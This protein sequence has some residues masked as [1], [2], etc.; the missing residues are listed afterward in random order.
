[1]LNQL[2]CVALAALVMFSTTLTFAPA[3]GAAY[4]TACSGTP[5]NYH[6][7]LEK[8]VTSGIYDAKATVPTL[9]A[10]HQCTGGT[11]PGS[12]VLPVNLQ[13]NGYC[14]LQI[15]WG[16]A[17]G[18][19]TDKWRVTGSPTDCGLDIP[20]GWP[21][22]VAGH[23]YTLRIR[24]Y[25]CAGIGVEAWQYVM[26]D[27]TVGGTYYFCGGGV[28]GKLPTKL[29]SGF[30]VWRSQDQYGGA[31]ASQAQYIREINYNGGTYLTNTTIQS[32]CGTRQS[33]WQA[34][35]SLYNSHAQIYAWT[36]N[37]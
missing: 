3:A 16:R 22:P 6:G 33:Y 23:T 15:G 35:S 25:E 29:W 17:Y 14:G 27:F 20:S 9:R 8:V 2:R 5:N 32:C 12:F 36:N 13:D 24:H 26:S 11:G 18:D 34:N 19:T 37:H 31:S 30:E 10:T 21:N 4:Y 28:I 1:M 7:Y